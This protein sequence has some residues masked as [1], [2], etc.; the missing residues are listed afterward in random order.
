MVT[1]LPGV[2]VLALLDTET[3]QAVGEGE[4]DGGGGGALTVSVKVA[5]AVLLPP[6]APT[7]IE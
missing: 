2:T 5:S 1:P 7:K 6:T 4:G 3:V